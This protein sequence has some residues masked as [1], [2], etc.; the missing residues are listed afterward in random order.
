VREGS[1]K[2]LWK[3]FQK[4]RSGKVD[5]KVTTVG[6]APKISSDIVKVP[7]IASSKFNMNIAVPF[8]SVLTKSAIAAPS[9]FPLLKILNKSPAL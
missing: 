7:D 5:T 1:M 4:T 8:P 6:R 9:L 3:H 2:L